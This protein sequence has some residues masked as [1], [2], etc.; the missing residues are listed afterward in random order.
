VAVGTKYNH[1]NDNERK[2]DYLLALI[3]VVSLLA[4]AS[5]SIQEAGVTAA[6]LDV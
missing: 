5:Q 2:N 4:G 1:L 6:E 3:D